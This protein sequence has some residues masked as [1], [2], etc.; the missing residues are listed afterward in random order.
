MQN[1]K[2]A[3]FADRWF[4]TSAIHLNDRRF[5]AFIIHLLDRWFCASTIDMFRLLKLKIAPPPHPLQKLSLTFHSYILVI[6][7]SVSRK[8]TLAYD[9]VSAEINS[10]GIPGL[11]EDMFRYN[12]WTVMDNQRLF[13]TTVSQ[14]STKWAKCIEHVGPTN[15]HHFNPYSAEI[16]LYKP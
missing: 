8:V 3:Y 11:P 5:C 12:Q 13:E 1:L 9:F 7:N 10:C 2:N 6:F 14:S 4:C 16:F 15:L